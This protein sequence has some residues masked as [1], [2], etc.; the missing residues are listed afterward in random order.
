M[1]NEPR[2]A[3][4]RDCCDGFTPIVKETCTK[5]RYQG[6]HEMPKVLNMAEELGTLEEADDCLHDLMEME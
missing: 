2:F 5:R 1:A 4:E 3:G 6:F